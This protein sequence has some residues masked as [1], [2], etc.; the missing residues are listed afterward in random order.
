[1]AIASSNRAWAIS[2]RTAKSSSAAWPGRRKGACRSSASPRLFLTGYFD[3]EEPTRRHALRLDGPE[4]LTLLNDTR[5]FDATFIVGFNE[6]R[7][8]DLYNTALIAR[9]GRVLG[10]YSKC[11]AYMP[12]HKQGRDF[13]V[14]E[15]DGVKF[16]VIIC[17]DGGYIEPSRIL[18]LQGAR[19]IIAPHFNRIPKHELIA[20]F[21]RSRPTTSPGPSK[22]RSGSCAGTTS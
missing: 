1:L 3:T 15:R 6:L 2:P 16:G 18:A 20:H 17:S 13:P 14:F 19:V 9:T 12:F 8:S 4:V 10:T 21:Q 5:I 7:G 22:T 11:T